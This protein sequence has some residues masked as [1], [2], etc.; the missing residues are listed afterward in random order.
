PYAVAHYVT[1]TGDRAILDEF[2][3]FIDGPALQEHES[4]KMFPPEVSRET[5]PLWE[6]CRRALD[7]G[8]RLG[9]HGL[10]L[11]GNGDWN[12][13]MNRVGIEGRGESVW[14]GWFLCATLDSFA[15]VMDGHGSGAAHTSEWR[16]RRSALAKAIDDSAWDGDWFRRGYFDDGTPLGS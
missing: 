2:V 12:D 14:L 6:H 15:C 1:I 3:P 5:A 11:F 13:G 4:E 7:H 8:Y 9:A 16:K 10:P